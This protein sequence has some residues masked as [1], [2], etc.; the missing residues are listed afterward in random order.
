MFEPFTMFYCAELTD[1]ELENLVE[2]E[3]GSVY[4]HIYDINDEELLNEE[5]DKIRFERLIKQKAKLL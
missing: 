5:G 2:L 1:Q 3:N 4:Y